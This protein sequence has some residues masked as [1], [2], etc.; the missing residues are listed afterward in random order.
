MKDIS[1][2]T[3]AYL[4]LRDIVFNTLR[5]AIINGDLEPGERL[6]EI[7]LADTLGVSRTPVREAIREL[8]NEGL[9]VMTPRKGAEVARISNKDLT[10][11]LEVRRV[12]E[13]LAM[14]LACEKITEE[15]LAHLEAN[16]NDFDA[17]TSNGTPTELS[18][19]DENFHEIIYHSTGNKRLIQILN[20]LRKQMYRYRFVYIK[21]LSHIKTLHSEHSEI[22]DALKKRDKE[23]SV[24]AI[25][26]HIDN[27]KKAI[28]ENFHF[29]C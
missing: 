10:D 3:D 2:K 22:L 27:Q 21:G 8:E 15:E 29:D 11:V 12:L 14:E 20:N 4:P 23:K 26:K 18:S 6:I 7:T 1:L 28:M 24:A 19:L 13:V 9:V 25:L 16:L 5:D 17:C